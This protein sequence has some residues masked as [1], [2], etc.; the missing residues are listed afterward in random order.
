MTIVRR[1]GWL[2][3]ACAMALALLLL[4]AAWPA[5]AALAQSPQANFTWV[6]ITDTHLGPS[7]AT[8]RSQ[9]VM[10]EI[11]A[12]PDRPAFLIHGGDLTEFG[13]TSEYNIWQ[14]M[15]QGWTVYATP[16]NHD[17]RWEDSGKGV[18][19]GKLGEPY[20]SFDY[21]GVHFILLDTAMNGSAYG[22]TD[23]AVLAWL[24]ADLA[25]VGRE[26]PVFIVSHHPL[27]YDVEEWMLFHDSDEPFLEVINDYNIIGVLTGHGHLHL[28][29]ERN[30]VPFYMTKAASEDGYKVIRVRNGQAEIWDHVTGQAPLLVDSRPLTPRSRPAWVDVTPIN[31]L[32]LGAGTP[33][34]TVSGRLIGIE[35]EPVKVRVRLNR[36]D[37]HEMKKTADGRWTADIDLRDVVPGMHRVTLKASLSDPQNFHAVYPG[38]YKKNVTISRIIWLSGPDSGPRLAWDV[39]VGGGIYNS[40]ALADGRLFFGA[41][42]GKVY[43]LQAS[44]GHVLW[45]YE[46]GRAIHAS[47]AV[48]DGTVYVASTDGKLYALRAS[49]GRLLWQQQAGAALVAAPL[50]AGDR[51]IIGTAQ[52]DL[53]AFA[54]ADG[55]PLWTT[56]LGGSVHSQPG[57][58]NGFVFAGSW[59]GNLRAVDAATG[60]IVWTRRLTN[61]NY[62][63]P[64]NSPPL[65][66]QGLV[67]AT[68]SQDSAMGSVGLWA[69]DA[70]TGDV[71]WTSQRGAG[72]ST[73]RLVNGDLVVHETS[74]SNVIGFD[75]LT[76]AER[77]V[78][79][80]GRQSFNS[81]PVGFGRELVLGSLPGQVISVDPALRRPAWRYQLGDQYVLGSPLAVTAAAAP[82]AMW[83]GAQGMVFVGSTDGT[84]YALRYSPPTAAPPASGYID[85]GGH[86]ARADVHGLERAG[87]VR[88][89]DTG[90]FRPDDPVTRAEVAAMVAGY[91]GLQGPS[92]GFASELVDLDGHWVRPFAEALEERGVILGSPAAGGLAFRPAD[93]LTRGEAATILSRLL[94][95]SRGS[96]EPRLRSGAVPFADMGRH[97]SKPWVDSLSGRGVIRGYPEDGTFRPDRTLTRG[98]MASLLARL[99]RGY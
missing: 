59:D 28:R 24:A 41:G 76:G 64:G 27:A 32:A 73:P 97:W 82:E 14:A 23:K 74:G 70:A 38:D 75:P 44:T 87:I 68:T 25:A 36:S 91:L 84:M 55:R 12:L 99:Q 61:N 81:S 65:Y 57:Y 86:W 10:D 45:T 7:G 26:R 47:P 56:G 60:E 42:D 37:W 93:T 31:D 83:P 6:H 1:S 5:G 15:S 85:L 90:R 17:S 9:K 63:A 35:S 30:G 19:R 46:T 96:E 95:L 49:D 40:P 33:S 34:L 94:G 98:E 22:H 21:Q 48:A 29:W 53:K 8:S 16:G 50:I 51:V 88:P 13:R 66:W 58:G 2:V 39:P 78:I 77:W 69:L 43:A 71:R 92:D 62:F 54:T 89:D 79:N 80:A 52:G 72:Y 4:A 11:A 3:R 20:R 18:F 67:F